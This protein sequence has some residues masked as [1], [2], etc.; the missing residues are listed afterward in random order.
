VLTLVAAPPTSAV[1][2]LRLHDSPI[3]LKNFNSL[4]LPGSKCALCRVTRNDLEGIGKL[5][6]SVPDLWGRWRQWRV[7]D[8]RPREG[9]PAA[10]AVRGSLFAARVSASPG[11]KPLPEQREESRL[12][13]VAP[14]SQVERAG[15]GARTPR[16]PGPV[17][18]RVRVLL[19]ICGVA[20]A[21]VPESDTGVFL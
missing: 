19:V 3:H 14:P 8:D 16:R 18:G 9:G 11:M 17:P 10:A 6:N 5:V 13:M 2:V 12:W 7:G 20:A 1:T 15:N 4:A 21:Q